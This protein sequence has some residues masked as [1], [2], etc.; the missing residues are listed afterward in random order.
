MR[1]KN[2]EIRASLTL[3]LPI[4]TCKVCGCTDEHA[5]YDPDYG[6]CWWVDERED[7]CSHCA[8]PEDIESLAAL[9]LMDKEE[10]DE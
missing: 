4:G 10:C 7:L 3:S 8:G 9:K 1:E 6:P 2:Y 5:C